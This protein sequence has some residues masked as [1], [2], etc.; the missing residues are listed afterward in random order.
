MSKFDH[1]HEI[2]QTPQTP[3]SRKKQV[4]TRSCYRI[5]FSTLPMTPERVYFYGILAGIDLKGKSRGIFS[6]E[7]C[8]SLLQRDVD[9]YFKVTGQKPA[10][11]DKVGIPEA[12]PSTTAMYVTPDKN[13]FGA[14]AE[15]TFPARVNGRQVTMPPE[16]HAAL[17]HNQM[18]QPGSACISRYG[19]FW[20]LVEYGFRLTDVQDCVVIRTHIPVPLQ[21]Y[22]DQG[23]AGAAFKK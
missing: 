17:Q 21:Q 23:T 18:V 4:T 1:L 12:N 6:F 13:K 3:K 22:F 20:D 8:E 7:V 2:I 19:L 16:F 15:I 9:R 11:Y 5:D 14:K 10:V